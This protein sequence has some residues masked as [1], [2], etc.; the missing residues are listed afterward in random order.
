MSAPL[1]GITTYGRD[2]GN[3]FSLP[4][5]YVDAV[6]RA[7]GAAV[8]LP[9]GEANVDRWL[10]LLDGVVLAGGGDL[11]P[12]LYGGSP[13]ETIYMVDAE[14]DRSEIAIARR[15]VASQLPALGIC[16]GMQV[17]NVALGGTLHEHLPDRFGD[18]V[19]HRAPPREPTSHAIRADASSRIAEIFGAHEFEAESWHHQAVRDL[20][21]G[22]VVVAHAPDGVIEAIEKPD[23]PWLYAVQWHPEL[24]ASR[25]P[26]QQRVFD[27]LVEAAI[28]LRASRA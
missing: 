13:H 28:R 24:S 4:A 7:G 19:R 8:L 9:P 22:L 1:I 26:V 5:D 11:D 15:I 10:D 17:L 2:E 27:R 3:R 20:A 16:R 6:R 25:D 21:A 14:R 18:S 12:R 23:H